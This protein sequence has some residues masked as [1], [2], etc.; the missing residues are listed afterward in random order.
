MGKRGALNTG[1][2]SIWKDSSAAEDAG[3]PNS[4][5]TL[6]LVKAA[7]SFFEGH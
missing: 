1:M 5:E 4:T 6:L 7:L 3:C 2:N